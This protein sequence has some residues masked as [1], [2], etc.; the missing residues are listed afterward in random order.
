MEMSSHGNSR[1]MS[2]LA[3]LSPSKALLTSC[4]L[5]F[6]QSKAQDRGQSQERS[7]EVHFAHHGANAVT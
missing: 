5:T 3:Q 4:V 6:G 1:G 7:K 2:G